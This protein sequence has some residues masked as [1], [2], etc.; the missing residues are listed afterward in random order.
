M[1]R[2]VKEDSILTQKVNVKHKKS[3][4]NEAVYTNVVIDKNVYDEDEPSAP[5]DF[6]PPPYRSLKKLYPSLIEPRH[7]TIHHIITMAECDPIS[8]WMKRLK[9]FKFKT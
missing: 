4:K 6:D 1:G 3:T 7:I 2:I 5:L 9:K 8:S